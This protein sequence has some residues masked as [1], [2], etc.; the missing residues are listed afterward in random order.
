MQRRDKYGV[1][2][3]Y[4]SSGSNLEKVGYFKL[5]FTL[6]TLFFM[7]EI[8]SLCDSYKPR[9][10]SLENKIQL[11]YDGAAGCWA[12]VGNLWHKSEE[13]TSYKRIKYNI[14]GR[15]P[16]IKNRAHI[17]KLNGKTSYHKR[18]TKYCNMKYPGEE[19]E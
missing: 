17:W 7:N 15:N 5:L 9:A 4:R 1:W 2:E 18:W 10:T 11:R 14:A 16:H 19:K 13:V 6:V 3:S 12:T 8:M